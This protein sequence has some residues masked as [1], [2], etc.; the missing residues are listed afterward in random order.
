LGKERVPGAVKRQ[1]T[2][3]LGFINLGEHEPDAAA[4]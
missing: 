2:V 1:G 3:A 4:S